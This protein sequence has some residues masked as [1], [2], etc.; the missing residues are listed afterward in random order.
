MKR[1]WNWFVIGLSILLSFVGACYCFIGMEE[2]LPIQSDE[3]IFSTICQ[4]YQGI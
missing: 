2:V 1:V 3:G 4:V